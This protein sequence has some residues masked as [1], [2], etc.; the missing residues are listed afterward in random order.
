MA[1]FTRDEFASYLHVTVDNSTTD[2]VE[3]VA[4]GWLMAA[5][6]LTARPTPVPDDMFGWAL[7]LAAIAYNN[8]TSAS[9][10]SQD[11]YSISHGDSVRRKEILAAARAVYGAAGGPL[12]SFPDWDWHW[13]TAPVNSPLT[14]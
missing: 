13:T 5:T 7:E 1:L 4:W 8:P 14:N 11:D 9:S 6:Q 10:E 12:Y 2:V 3:R